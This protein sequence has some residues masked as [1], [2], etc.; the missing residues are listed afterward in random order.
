ME[1]ALNNEMIGIITIYGMLRK[2]RY[3]IDL[4]KDPIC[5][6]CSKEQETTRHTIHQCP[7]LDG[8]RRRYL[9]N[10]SFKKGVWKAE[11]ATSILNYWD[12][13]LTVNNLVK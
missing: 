5:S 9:G 13:L 12:A 2:Y 4:D 6:F 3:R 10:C 8:C 7:G 11:A 1:G